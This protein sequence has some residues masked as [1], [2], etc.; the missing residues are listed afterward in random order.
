MSESLIDDA[1][2]VVAAP[3]AQVRF[4]GFAAGVCSV[5]VAFRQMRNRK[6]GQ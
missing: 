1:D 5:S 2:D 3:E 4:A 6:S